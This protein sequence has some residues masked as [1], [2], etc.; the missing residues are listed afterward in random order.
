MQDM[1]IGESD[2]AVHLMGDAGSD[3]GGL[4]AANL[5]RCDLKQ[6]GVVIKA[7]VGD[8]IGR[9]RRRGRSRSNLTAEPRKAVLDRLEFR[10]RLL[11]RDTLLRIKN[12]KFEDPVQSARNLLRSHS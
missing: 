6:R 8:G 2:R 7:G 3:L 9:R 11:E 1:F 10:D 5:S 12:R 4:A